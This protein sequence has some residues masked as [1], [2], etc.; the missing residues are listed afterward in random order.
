MNIYVYTLSYTNPS[1]ATQSSLCRT[2]DLTTIPAG[3]SYVTC[4]GI[5]MVSPIIL[6]GSTYILD[7]ATILLDVQKEQCQIISGAC[8]NTILAGVTSNASGS[9]ITYTM[10]TTDQTNFLKA[11]IEANQCLNAAVPWTAGMTVQPLGFMVS[12]GNYYVNL[13]LTAGTTGTT[14]PTLPALSTTYG[15]TVTDNTVLWVQVFDMVSTITNP[16]FLNP[17]QIK[18]LFNDVS[19]FI[20]NNRIRCYQLN[21]Q[22]MATTTVAG[23]QAIVW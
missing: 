2:T 3:V 17:P 11:S 10:S 13:N 22:I 6:S 7:T 20:L 14:L 5:D 9:S 21:Q 23:A 4:T 8:A 12:A 15:Q 1:G 19:R 16:V 18:Q